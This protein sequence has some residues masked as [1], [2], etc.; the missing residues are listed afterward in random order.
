MKGKKDEK[1]K[2]SSDFIT[3]TFIR[4]LNTKISI[5]TLNQPTPNRPNRKKKSNQINNI[6]SEYKL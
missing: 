5:Y 4:R 1:K 2:Y 3:T 6:L